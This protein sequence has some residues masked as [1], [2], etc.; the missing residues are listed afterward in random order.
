[1]SDFKIRSESHREISST[2]TFLQSVK[3]KR[4]RLADCVCPI[5]SACRSSLQSKRL[6]FC[7]TKME[8]GFELRKWNFFSVHQ[9]K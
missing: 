5:S 7:S 8:R 9:Q 2:P 3:I 4:L 1:M 6:Y